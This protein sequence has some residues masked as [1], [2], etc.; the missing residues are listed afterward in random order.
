VEKESD[1]QEI[2]RLIL[3]VRLNQMAIHEYEKDGIIFCQILPY[4]SYV[5]IE[6]DRLL[7]SDEGVRI[8]NIKGV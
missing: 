3:T 8:I 1:V 4:F 7:V 5:D 2:V 6:T